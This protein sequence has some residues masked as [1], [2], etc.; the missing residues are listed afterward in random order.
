MALKRR[1]FLMFLGAGAGSIALQPLMQNGQKFSMPFQANSALAQNAPNGLSFVP[2]KG[3]MPLETDGVS[4]DKQLDDYSQFSVAD[5]VVLPEGF[6]YDVIAAWGDPIG[7]TDHFGYNNDYLSFVETAPGEGYLT[8]NHEYI[9]VKPWLQTY[10]EVLGKALPFAEVIAA[11]SAATDQKVDAFALPDGD[12]LKEKIKEISKAAQYEVGLSVIS[13]RK[14]SDGRWQRT[15]DASDR[16]ITGISGLDDGRYLK[17]TGPAVAV[18]RKQQGI[19][20]IDGLG[21][22]IIG[23]VNNCGGGTSPWGTILSAEENFQDFVPEAVNADGTSL[24]PSEKP[25]SLSETEI[26]GPSNVF[27]LAGNKYGWMVEIDPANPNDYG[28]KHTWLGRFRHE[29]VAIRAVAG[30]ALAVYSGCDRR[31]GHVYKFVS[32]DT[33]VNPQSKSN[34]RLLEN[35]IL[36]AAK[37]NPNGTGQ[38]IALT[39][40]TPVNPDLP[41]VHAGGMIPLPKRP[42]GGVVKVTDDAEIQ[43]FKQQYPTLGS[44]YI[45]TEQERQGAI[46]ID[47]HYAAN[48]VGATCTARPE[49]TDLTV[50]GTLFIAF[51]SGAPSSSDGSP[52]KEVFKGP[53]GESPYEYGWITKLV[54]DGNNPAATTFKWENFATGGEPAEGGLGFAN[55]DNLDFDKSGNLWMVTDMS[56]EKLNLEIASRTKAD[57]SA[58]SQSDLRA[59]YGNNSIWFMP[60]SGPNAGEAYLFGYGPMDSELTGPFFTQDQQTLFLA[61]QHPGEINGRRENM[62]TETRRFALK[63]TTGQE[64]I[65][66]REV[67]IGS[68]WPGKERN[69]PPKP[70]VVAI[71]RV[72][73][74]RIVG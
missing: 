29:A 68:N 49:D 24:P 71:R 66:T 14:N 15:N 58:V 37:F 55:P 50:D 30:K 74:D 56:S 59:L 52:N 38:W 3:P 11:V 51:T 17:A 70:A 69:A 61:A 10:A 16:R 42:E 4:L 26:S 27:G 33:V 13:I 7:T 23:T 43:A 32:R 46:L 41:S 31:G 63:T 40:D 64:F 34:S 19:G 22:R 53:N 12:P 25:F 47:A 72:D 5:D 9:S 45:G 1:N 67:P 18:F 60:T 6:T 28:T 65:Q 62:A 20:Y 44:L 21:D 36:Y 8:V 39:P 54:E 73:G 35:G 57:G 2:I 48:A